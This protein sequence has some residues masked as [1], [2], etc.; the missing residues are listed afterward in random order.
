[1]ATNAKS[2]RAN[3]AKPAPAAASITLQD[4]ETKGLKVIPKRA[5]FR[6]AGYAFPAEGMTIPIIDLS[7]AQYKL[8]TAE[9]ML[10]SVVVDLESAG[11]AAD[12]AE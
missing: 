4:A 11:A 3:N 6:R 10:I 7:P 2:P 5:G 12:T 1:M 8:I 9:P